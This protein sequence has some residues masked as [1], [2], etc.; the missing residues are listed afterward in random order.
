MGATGDRNSDIVG[1][2]P[3]VD[4]AAISLVATEFQE[5]LPA[6]SPDGRWLTY[7][8][9]RTGR[10]EIYVSPFPNVDSARV[11]VSIEG[12]IVPV[13]A[14]TGAEL[15]YVDADLTL[16]S[17]RVETASEFRVTGREALFPLPE[18]TVL[19]NAGLARFYDV[20]LDDQ[21]FVMGRR[22][23]RDGGIPAARIFLV[24]NFFEELKRLVPN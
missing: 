15:F 21:R 18:G 3:G 13:W 20:S 23:E 4:S 17:A 1:L 6:L 2:H 19:N 22:I 9:N 24:N 5:R 7:S 12:G 14:H 10:N 16:V 8:S 11:L